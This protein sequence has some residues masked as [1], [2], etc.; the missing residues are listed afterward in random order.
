MKTFLLIGAAALAG[1]A[2]LAQTAPPAP[3]APQVRP[4]AD[5]VMTRA[6]TVERVRNHFS[7]LDSD[8]DGAITTAEL[9]A[10]H[11]MVAG[12]AEGAPRIVMHQRQ[13]GDP[14]AAFDRL[15]TDRNGWIGRDEFAKGREVRIEKRVER[16][17]KIKE[18]RKDGKR[19]GMRM[20]RMGGMGGGAHMIVMADTNKDGRITLQEA[21]AMALQHFDQMD[22]NRDGQITRDERRSGRKVMIQRMRAPTAG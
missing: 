2:A 21:E 5:G 19:A 3:P 1:T 16:R 11:G 4:M 18:A 17:E 9:S 8:R 7:R 20:H 12:G 10:R 22:S 14:N 6:E 13:M 15:D